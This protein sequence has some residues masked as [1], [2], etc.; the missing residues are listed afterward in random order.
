MLQ[1]YFLYSILVW[2]SIFEA[3]L[4]VASY[5]FALIHIREQTCEAEPVFHS[6]EKNP[7]MPARSAQNNFKSRMVHWTRAELT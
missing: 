5:Y 2:I 6:N 1:N 7:K 4:P 3:D